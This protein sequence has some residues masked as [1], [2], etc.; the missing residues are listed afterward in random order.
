MTGIR[1]KDSKGSEIDELLG[2]YRKQREGHEK[3]FGKIGFPERVKT[4]RGRREDKGDESENE[5]GPEKRA[6]LRAGLKKRFASFR[7]YAK[8][9]K[10]RAVIMCAVFVV[11]A[12]AAGGGIYAAVDY[13]KTAYL[14]PYQEQY[15]NVLFPQGIR[16]EYCE[17]YA[18]N[19][20]ITGRLSVPGCGF[21]SYVAQGGAGALPLLDYAN[22]AGGLDFNTVIYIDSDKCD[23]EK[24][25]ANADSYLKSDQKITYST[26]YEDYEFYVIG[27]FY[28]NTLPFDDSDY[29]FPYNV[30]QRMTPLSFGDYADRLYHRFLYDSGYRLDYDGDKLLTLSVPSD[31]MPHFEFVVVCALGAGEQSQ[32]QENNSV[33]YPQAWYDEHDM[34]NPYRFASKWYP[35]IYTDD[36]REETSQQSEKDY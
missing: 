3:H 14:R 13:Q 19:P 10:G 15:P 9:K 28:T 7:A 26:L 23:L 2:D 4:R 16:E 25:Y 29:V 20:N 34:Q 24:A 32:A 12:A 22:S 35:V 11:A 36:T 1:D 31:F 8:S 27:A 5:P 30:T 6:S 33:H 17:A 18:Q 21:E